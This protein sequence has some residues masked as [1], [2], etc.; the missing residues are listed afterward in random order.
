M[1]NVSEAA[2]EFADLCETAIDCYSNDE[3]NSM[4]NLRKSIVQ[5]GA[6]VP[7]DDA[8]RDQIVK[9]YLTKKKTELKNFFIEMDWL[10]AVM[11]YLGYEIETEKTILQFKTRKVEDD[12]PVLER[13]EPPHYEYD[14]EL[15]R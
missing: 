7:K 2:K 11:H 4:Y 9:P 1:R 5:A 6:K 15:E 10:I 14:D 12:P 8:K 3:L 13:D